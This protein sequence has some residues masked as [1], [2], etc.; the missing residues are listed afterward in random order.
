MTT[1]QNSAIDQW[2][3]AHGLER[4]PDSSYGEHV[5]YVMVAVPGRK[6]KVRVS[7]KR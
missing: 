5:R 6:T 1:E 2:C 4:L 3:S 7:V